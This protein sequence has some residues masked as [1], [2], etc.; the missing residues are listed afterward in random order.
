MKRII[1]PTQISL[2][3]IS[4][5]AAQL[6][7]LVIRKRFSDK[8]PAKS[9]LEKQ[10]IKDG[11]RHERL[12]I[13]RFVEENKTVAKIGDFPEN[14]KIEA[15]LNAMKNKSEYI[16]QAALENSDMKGSADVL[17]RINQPSRLGDWS[18][19]PIEC[20]LSSKSKTT[21]IIQSCAYCD[22]LES[23]QGTRANNFELYLGGKNFERFETKKY[24]NWY[25][26]IKQ[27]YKKF[28]TDF[29]E[30]I[31]PE[32]MPGNHGKWSDYI[33]EKLKERRDLILVAGM[34]KSQRKKLINNDIKTIEDFAFIKPEN[35][36]FVSKKDTLRN[37]H[38]QAKVQLLKKSSD[39][40]PNFAPRNWSVINS[41]NT[42]KNILPLK[43]KGD[44]WFDM[45]GFHDSVTG[46][47]LEYLFGACF[48]NNGK[49]EF[50]KWWAHN[51][52]QEEEAFESWVNW[53]E[54]RRTNYPDLHIYHYGNY[55]KDAMRNLQQKHPNSPAVGKIDDWLRDGLLI[56]LLLYS[57]TQFS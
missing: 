55:E 44:I 32:L 40:K 10:L 33:N 29:N 4:E 15:T 41:D 53:V 34:T 50:E 8:I 42:K 57:K 11:E 9:E 16:Y 19:I 24:W 25:F 48:E 52:S 43:N 56:D 12:L 2:F 13:K 49:I 5:L 21:F 27:R 17:K 46:I 38:N 20:K 14:Q 45:E 35:K 7:E 18:Y 3:A 51:H 6:E 31:T 39:G 1:T 30:E 54:D 22:L 36:I 37:L 47:K 26:S 28:L 23:I